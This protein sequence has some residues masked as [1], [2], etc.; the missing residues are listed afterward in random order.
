MVIFYLKLFKFSTVST[1]SVSWP[2][3]INLIL[4]FTFTV[5]KRKHKIFLFIGK[6]KS[7]NALF[8]WI[9]LQQNHSREN[10]FKSL[11]YNTLFP[12]IY[13]MDSQSAWFKRD[14]SA[15]ENKF[16]ENFLVKS[17]CT[18]SI[19]EIK[20]NSNRLSLFLSLR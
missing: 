16:I 13:I 11:R 10:L 3:E 2:S 9:S 20:I 17:R 15:T 5:N 8:H 7:K 4:I 12:L 19:T 18:E 6:F 1:L 14:G